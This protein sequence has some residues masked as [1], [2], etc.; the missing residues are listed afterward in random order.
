MAPRVFG[1]AMIVGEV[2]TLDHYKLAFD[3]HLDAVAKQR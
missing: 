3:A 2:P 1:N